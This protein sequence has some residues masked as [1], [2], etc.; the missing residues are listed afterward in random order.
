MM[1]SGWA[2]AVVFAG[3][4]L[5]AARIA[6]RPAVR[7]ELRL[8]P[9]LALL[10]LTVA[11]L[12]LAVLAGLA[13]QGVAVR[14]TLAGMV[15][16]LAGLAWYRARPAYGRRRGLPPGSL[17]LDVSL[18]AVDDE[19]FYAD[20]FRRWGGV[21]KF[22]QIH[23]PVACVT[24]LRQAREFLGHEGGAV[25]QADWPFHRLLPGK[26]VEF[27][28]GVQHARYR[29]LL[30]PA[31]G[32]DLVQA[33]APDL[34]EL[35]RASVSEMAAA[36]VP[37]GV[38]PFAWTER[39]AYAALL[40]IL[41]GID[42]AD[43][44]AARLPALLAALDRP[45]HPWL[46]LPGAS[47]RAIAELM[48]RLRDVAE[49]CAASQNDAAPRCVVDELLRLDPA[50]VGDETMVGNL[51]TLLHDGRNMLRML[52]AWLVQRAAAHPD[53]LARIRSA[54]GDEN[55]AAARARE[56]VMEVLRTSMSPYLY[57]KVT[58]DCRLGQYRIPR[59]WLVRICL[60]EAHHSPRTFE[61]PQ[62]FDP[63]RFGPEH[64]RSGEFWPFS[65]GVHA[66]FAEGFVMA[67]AT[68]FMQELAAH[69]LQALSDGPAERNNRH[70]AYAVPS[71]QLRVLLTSATGAG[72]QAIPGPGA[73]AG[74]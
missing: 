54:R 16:L 3:A 65:I 44:R 72:P 31:F 18:K 46:P 71:R 11:L 15:V 1:A 27:M 63:T 43:P 53:C 14:Q 45:V 20:G 2:E 67:V 21:F 22:S 35:S 61:R 55:A 8:H 39:L 57:R 47:R 34:R 12:T 70:W 73:R 48:A 19:N 7:R 60:R 32:P 24:D 68:G 17:A 37:N 9:A 28:D 38:A 52:L 26:Y 64:R 25:G 58:A 13:T 36:S 56:F 41:V 4:L 49:A 40:R 6:T 42:A 33:W 23:R 66:C 50:M 29:A 10:A 59:G 69:H 5:A 62:E 51:A 74:G 30:E